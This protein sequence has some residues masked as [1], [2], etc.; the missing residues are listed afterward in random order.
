MLKL[1]HRYMATNKAWP[2][3]YHQLAGAWVRKRNTAAT[4]THANR[5]LARQSDRDETGQPYS[6]SVVDT[7][8][9][10]TGLS[11]TDLQ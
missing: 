1:T 4:P 9:G 6:R 8:D 7:N 3:W 2:T 10:D 11:L 5:L